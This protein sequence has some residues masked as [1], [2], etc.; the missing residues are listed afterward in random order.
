MRPEGGFKGWMKKWFHGGA[1]MDK[2]ISS[3]FTALLE[4]VGK[5][6][7]K[8][9]EADRDGRLATIILCDQ[10]SRNCFRRQAKAFSFDSIS[11]RLAKQIYQDP[12][13]WKDYKYNEKAFILMPIMHSENPAD[14]A[15]CLNAF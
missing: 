1:E 13:L 12:N 6:Q 4:A 14:G 10:F 3:R 7:Y 2:V 15:L 9:W 11:L 8:H 5:G